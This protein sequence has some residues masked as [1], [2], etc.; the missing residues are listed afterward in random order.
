MPPPPVCADPAA[1]RAARGSGAHGGGGSGGI[2]GAPGGGGDGQQGRGAGGGRRGRGQQQLQPAAGPERGVSGGRVRRTG[3]RTEF[4]SALQEDAAGCGWRLCWLPCASRSL[5]PPLPTPP[6]AQQ[7]PHGQAL[8]PRAGTARRRQLY[9]VWLR[10]GSH[11]CALCR[12]PG[13]GAAPPCTAMWPP[14]HVACFCSPTR[15]LVI[16]SSYDNSK[17]I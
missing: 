13:R 8:Q 9:R 2:R 12:A 10:A 7:L 1:R 15:L 16:N 4:G 14:V 3:W 5:F 11:G 6:P 17:N